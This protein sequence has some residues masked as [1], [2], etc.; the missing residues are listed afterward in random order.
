MTKEKLELKVKK[1][2]AV[3]KVAGAIAEMVRAGKD[4]ELHA[5]GAGSVNQSVKAIAT[6]RGYVAS[7]GLDLLTIPGFIV[8]DIEGE[9]RTGIKFIIKY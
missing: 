5:I 8:V 1:D 2:S 9:Q 3:N 6:A 4:V 7:N